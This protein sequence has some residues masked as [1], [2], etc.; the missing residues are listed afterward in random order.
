[1]KNN[2]KKNPYPNSTKLNDVLNI[3]GWYVLCWVIGICHTCPIIVQLPQPNGK[4]LHD[5]S[6]IILIWKFPRKGV[7]FVLEEER[8][9]RKKSRRFE[10]WEKM[11]R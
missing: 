9:R 10:T 6:G 8:R 1:M 4:E 5:F 11:K 2:L 3:I 7:S